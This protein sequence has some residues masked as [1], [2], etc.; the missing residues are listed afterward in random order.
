MECDRRCPRASERSARG[1]EQA[2]GARRRVVGHADDGEDEQARHGEARRRHGRDGRQ[3][4]E[5]EDEASHDRPADPGDHAEL[6]GHGDRLLEPGGGDHVRDRGLH[7]GLVERLG[8]E[9]E[10]EH[11]DRD[12][13]EGVRAGAC[14]VGRH[15][16]G[17]EGVERRHDAAL[18]RAVGYHAADG[19]EQGVGD[20][21]RGE[22]GA[23]QGARPGEVQ[24]VQGQDEL[25]DLHAQQ[26]E[27]LRDRDGRE[28]GGEQGLVR[29][30]VRGF[31]RRVV[32]GLAGGSL[33]ARRRVLTLRT[34]HREGRFFRPPAVVS[35]IA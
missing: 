17:E 11:R 12:G 16:E 14:E 15:H 9:G 19:R 5:A 3:A 35:P 27:R 33:R 32:R 10:H 28:A 25:E 2:R 13:H 7:A 26:R 8:G 24:E 34:P 22:H 29:A 1:G 18:A 30:A 6:V 4:A 23:V 21:P 20:E 31:A